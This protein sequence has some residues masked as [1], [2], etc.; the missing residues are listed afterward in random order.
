MCVQAIFPRDGVGSLAWW[1]QDATY[2]ASPFDM[3]PGLWFA[4]GGFMEG[5]RTHIY[6]W[7]TAGCGC[8]VSERFRLIP[9]QNW[10]FTTEL[11]WQPRGQRR[12]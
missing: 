10:Q 1:G 11:Q 9:L 12:I 5:V 6:I 2:M 3:G 4:H 8:V 7:P